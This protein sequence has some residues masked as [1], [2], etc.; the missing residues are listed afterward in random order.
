MKK[1]KISILKGGVLGF[2]IMCAGYNAYANE[3]EITTCA[4]K[5]NSLQHELLTG[6]ACPNNLIS[7][8]GEISWKI[9]E[10]YISSPLGTVDNENVTLD[11]NGFVKK[12]NIKREM[13]QSTITHSIKHVKGKRVV[14]H[15][16][17]SFNLNKDVKQELK[18]TSEPCK[19]EYVQ[20][21]IEVTSDGSKPVTIHSQEKTA[22]DKP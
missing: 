19:A 4:I 21:D 9:C 13:A 10:N 1:N 5:V 7:C 15:T 14:V 16:T 17:F 6:K 20:D 3:C 11:N 8:E 2:G 18:A 12:I 22:P